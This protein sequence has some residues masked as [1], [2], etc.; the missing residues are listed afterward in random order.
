MF[1]SFLFFLLVS[2]TS[3]A[4]AQVLE[5][6]GWENGIPEQFIEST[7][8]STARPQI[9]T[10]HSCNGERAVK[11]F[12]NHREDNRGFR[13]EL[14][15]VG[16]NQDFD[17]GKEYWVSWAIYL[18]ND[19]IVD[20][21]SDIL[22]QFH[23]VPDRD[24][25]GERIENYRNPNVALRTGSN[26]NWVFTVRGDDKKITA[27][28]EY[29]RFKAFDL[30]DFMVDRNKWTTFTLRI[31]FEYGPEGRAELWKDGEKVVDDFG[32]N[33]FN[34]DT[35]PYLKIGIYKP[36]WKG[37]Y[38]GVENVSSRTIFYDE[39]KVAQNSSLAEMSLNCGPGYGPKPP[40]ILN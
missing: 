37:S 20:K 9:T 7:S 4:F 8:I 19:Y 27:N 34:D 1:K 36:S 2:V 29:S 13:N 16:Q 35:P 14:T 40:L 6:V 21:H 15:L 38:G 5:S 25:A 11:F 22:F 33:A 26:G 17:Y 28:N 24:A 30:G 12:V 10:A 18:P 39:L 3:G 32:E 31:V 23:G